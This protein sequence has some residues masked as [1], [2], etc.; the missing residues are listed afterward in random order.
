[1]RTG[2]VARLVGCSVNQVRKLEV[3]GVLPPALRSPSGRRS[4]DQ[5]HV[6]S[7]RAYRGLAEAV[8][9]VEARHILVTAHLSLDEVV[10]RLD[11][12]HALLHAERRELALARQ[13]VASIASEPMVDVRAAD[14]MG[15]GELA[16]ALGVRA[17]ALR[18]W[19]AEGLLAPGRD[20]LGARMY[21]PA[22][23]RDARLIHQMRR[24]GYRIEPLR[25]LLP[26]LRE[27]GWDER[28]AEREAS[29][30][31][32]SVALFRASALLE[33]LCPSSDVS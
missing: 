27:G 15:V 24:A 18:H 33:E 4:F 28:L 30:T 14:A 16:E 6:L 8:G 26:Q 31:A 1:V 2:E 19:E 10:A 3:L 12:V 9:P 7:A 29:I 32:R 25:A 21:S 22:D 11:A 20:A 17:S 5:A 13:A 23:V